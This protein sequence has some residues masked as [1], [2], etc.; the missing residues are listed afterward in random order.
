MNVICIVYT[1]I[2]TVYIYLYV[3]ICVCSSRTDLH[4][5]LICLYFLYMSWS[6]YKVRNNLCVYLHLFVLLCDCL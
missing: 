6:T 4:V 2:Q 5:V 3:N 1:R